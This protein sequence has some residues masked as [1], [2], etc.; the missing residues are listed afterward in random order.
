MKSPPLLRE[1]GKAVFTHLA[2]Y[3][4]WGNATSAVEVVKTVFAACRIRVDQL[5]RFAHHP[6]ADQDAEQ[7]RAA[8]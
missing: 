1:A 4:G 7:K 2:S 6:P 3:A 5:L 8:R